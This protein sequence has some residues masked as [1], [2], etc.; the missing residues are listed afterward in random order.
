MDFKL[1]NRETIAAEDKYHRIFWC[2][3]LNRKLT[4]H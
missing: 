2:V 1:L 4:P 3:I